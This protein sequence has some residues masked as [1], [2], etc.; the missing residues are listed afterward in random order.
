[1][2]KQ[3]LFILFV[4][5]STHSSYSKNVTQEQVVTFASKEIKS[6]EV[7]FNGN[8]QNIEPIYIE[9]QL[10]YYTVN[11]APQGWALISADDVAAPLLAY[12]CE[13]HYVHENQ[14][15]SM[16]AWMAGYA[17][18]ILELQ[19]TSGLK[20]QSEWDSQ[21]R[22]R[23]AGGR[24]NPFI[25][26]NWNQSAPYNAYCPSNTNGRALVGCVAVAMAQAMSVSRTPARPK[27]STSYNSDIY[28]ALGINYDTEGTYNWNDI[29]SGANNK[30]EVARLLYHCGI[31][32]KMNYSTTGSGAFSSDI[33]NAL[34]QYF[35]YSS[36]V[37]S[38]SRFSNIVEW[39]NLLYTELQNGRPIVYSGNDG[40]GA[41]GHAFNL[42]GYDGTSMYH[43]NWGWGGSNNGYYRID[44]LHDQ[45]SNYTQGHQAVVGIKTIYY[46]PSNITLS[47]ASIEESQTIGTV[48]GNIA[49]E[50]EIPPENGYDYELKGPYNILIDDY[51]PAGFYIENDILKS[52][53]VFTYN[54]V[55]KTKTVYIKAINRTNRLAYEKMFNITIQKG[56]GIKLIEEVGNIRVYSE[57]HHLYINVDKP[58]RYVLYAFTGQ[59]IN[60]STLFAGKNVLPG[61]IA[62]G[63]YLLTV[64]SDN[65]TY[66]KKIC[67]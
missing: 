30:N 13:G 62:N 47:N 46:G 67:L 36:S 29:M 11:Y 50:S 22:L 6:R 45:Y 66:T 52:K 8:V 32:V 58:C 3:I 51:M 9:G 1:M 20:K 38:Y 41:V 23:S 18:Q 37:R 42:D 7:S 49:V 55:E 2:R 54:D 40:T 31:A 44:N 12:S 63:C 43:V 26:V 19:K 34:K 56:T 48:V 21:V 27:G 15:E 24:I 59:K 64:I 53:E 61:Q 25:N 28:G 35:S 65:S 5:L 39:E 10:V 57:N 17:K 60:E 14:P 16:Q 33:P 4:L